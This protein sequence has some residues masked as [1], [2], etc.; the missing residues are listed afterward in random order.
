MSGGGVA[1]LGLGN[2]IKGKSKVMCIYIYTAFLSHETCQRRFTQY[3]GEGSSES[4]AS[5]PITIFTFPIKILSRC[6]L[7]ASVMPRF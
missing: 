1:V 6:C 5:E 3:I 4:G 2:E 7:V